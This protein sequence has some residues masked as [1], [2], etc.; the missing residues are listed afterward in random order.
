MARFYR[1]D[2]ADFLDDNIYAAP[3]Q[4]MAQTIAAQDQKADEYFATAEALQGASDLISFLDFDKERERVS[5]IQGK[6][7]TRIDELTG[8]MNEN[9][10]GYNEYMPELK[11]LQ[12]E[13]TTDKTSG[14]WFNIE[15]RRRDVAAWEADE[16]NKK[17]KADSPGLYNQMRNHFYQGLVERATENSS[18]R[19]EGQQIVQRP[20]IIEKYHKIFNDL[21]ENS[22]DTLNGGYIVSGKEVSKERLQQ[23]AWN[24]LR[25]DPSFADYANQMGNTL[26]LESFQGDNLN[27]FLLMKDGETITLEQLEAMS[28]EERAGVSQVINPDNP[29][30]ADM[31]AATGFASGGQSIEAD[32]FALQKTAAALAREQSGVDYKEAYNLELLKQR[33]AKEK[34]E[35]Q[36]QNARKLAIEKGDIVAEGSIILANNPHAVVNVGELDA[37]STRYTDLLSTKP[38][39]RTEAEQIEFNRLNNMYENLI[40]QH[41]DKII[42]AAGEPVANTN[43]G[44][45]GQV[46]RLLGRLA[47]YEKGEAQPREIANPNYT[48]VPGMGS[49]HIKDYDELNKLKAFKES[50]NKVFSDVNKTV[51]EGMVISRPYIPLNKDS[52]LGEQGLIMLDNMFQGSN[53]AIHSSNELIYDI[54][55]KLKKKKIVDVDTGGF[56]DD[57]SSNNPMKRILTA[58]G[59]G[60]PSELPSEIGSFKTSYE[61]GE[62]LFEFVPASPQA[63]EKLGIDIKD[64][65]YKGESFVMRFSGMRNTM[66]ENLD[67]SDPDQR[68][69][70]Q[71]LD[72]ARWKVNDESTKA[73]GFLD[74]SN[75]KIE[76]PFKVPLR[77]GKD[78]DFKIKKYSDGTYQLFETVNY[79][80]GTQMWT[81]SFGGTQKVLTPDK[82]E[83]K[84]Y[85][86]ERLKSTE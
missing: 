62:T 8:K 68:N 37:M 21:K 50:L 83:I 7:N 10:L 60:K 3:W 28:P 13:M 24:M 65:N 47:S 20:E 69:L 59:V 14:E 30:A 71:E 9:L 75:G 70:M 61:N 39:S 23:L 63:L 12:R 2:S 6:Y 86:Y 19:F 35:Q 29:F 67:P 22:R 66:I 42:K 81:P 53:P 4:L 31:A 54:N 74:E 80:N 33:G 77:S 27:P 72:P 25:A 38:S 52:K 57:G 44:K 64:R 58:A 36:H 48:G 1:T 18:A 40:F 16:S 73:F 17:A 51:A 43:Q 45:I 49:T 84:E 85:L 32:K 11:K 41:G 55:G 26:G 34:V 15:Q 5:E 82:L 79:K 46:Q 56:L 76:R 78:I